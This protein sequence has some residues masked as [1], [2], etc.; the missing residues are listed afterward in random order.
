[1]TTYSAFATSLGT[2]LHD[3]LATGTLPTTVSASHDFG[4]GAGGHGTKTITL[5]LP[6]ISPRSN[7]VPAS[8]ITSAI[9]SFVPSATQSSEMTPGPFL[10]SFLSQVTRYCVNCFIPMMPGDSSNVWASKIGT[11]Y[12]S[13]TVTAPISE[14]GVTFSAAWVNN[15]QMAFSI[16]VQESMNHT[17]TPVTISSTASSCSSSSC[18]SSCSCSS[19]SSSSSSSSSCSSSW[20]VAF[21]QLN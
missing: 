8:T 17:L 2:A 21:Y 7:I 15:L 10:N 20:F 3:T 4:T 13:K 19:T 11:T 16:V 14:N 12:S 9:L 18:S 1:M 6:S 5:T